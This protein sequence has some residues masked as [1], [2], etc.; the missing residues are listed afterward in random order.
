MFRYV[1]CWNNSCSLIDKNWFQVIIVQLLGFIKKSILLRLTWPSWRRQFY[2]WCSTSLW[3]VFPSCILHSLP[4]NGED[5]VLEESC[6]LSIGSRSKWR[7][8]FSWKRFYSTTVIGWDYF[9]IIKNE[10][11]S[12]CILQAFPLFNFLSVH[13]QATSRMDG[14]R[15]H[16]LH[17]RPPRWAYLSQHATHC[18][19]TYPHEVSH[20]YFDHV[21]HSGSCIYVH[22]SLWLSSPL[23]S[24]PRSPWFP[25]P[26]VGCKL[27]SSSSLM[28]LIF[29]RFV[30]NYGM[31]GVLDRLHGTDRLFR[32]SKAYER[33]IMLL[34]FVPLSQQFPDDSKKEK[35]KCHLGKDNELANTVF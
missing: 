16:N 11:M 26:Q 13:P 20:C 34:G 29:S 32:A 9:L 28:N 22:F 27:N 8:L 7:L 30:N 10:V 21:V 12:N 15:G 35:S 5:A 18:H 2:K 14:T 23:S 25:S 33:H 6:Q 24:F 4:C 17:L 1:A 31:L 3:W 19:G